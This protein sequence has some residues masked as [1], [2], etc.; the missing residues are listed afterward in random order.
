MVGSGTT[1][2]ALCR[3]G[4]IVIDGPIAGEDDVGIKLIVT[5]IA[6]KTLARI[7]MREREALLDKAEAFAA[8]PFAVHPAATPLRG[9]PD[10]IRLR[11]GDWR[12][13]CRV[14]RAADTIVLE[15]VA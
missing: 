1:S 10:A 12:A 2:L 7:P 15:M 13:I 6:S 3:S 8:A 9:Q 14:D 4:T 11:Q 5:R